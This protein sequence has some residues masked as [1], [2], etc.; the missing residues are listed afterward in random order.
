MRMT[1][2]EIA[3]SIQVSPA[4]VSIVRAGKPWVSPFTR[5]RIQMKLEEN[6]YSHKE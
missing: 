2:S 3:A 5:R 6:G 4:S 1:L